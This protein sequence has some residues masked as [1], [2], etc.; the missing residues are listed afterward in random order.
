MAGESNEFLSK[1]GLQYFFGRLKTIFVQQESGKGL[2]T[3]DYTTAEKTKL[4]GIAAGA[5]ANVIETIK[6]NGA[7]QT[8]TSK[9]VDISVPTNLS[10]LANDGN[11]VTD[12]NYVHTDSNY[13]SAEKT[14][15]SGIA[16]GAQVNVIETVKVN[17]TAL[18]VTSKAVD[19]TVP[20]KTSDITNDSNYVAD[21]AY[22]HTE[23]NF[24]TTLKNKLDGIEEGAEANVAYTISMDNP[25][26]ANQTTTYKLLADGEAVSGSSNIIF[27]NTTGKNAPS[28]TIGM[29]QH[30]ISTAL[31]GK[32]DTLDAMTQSEA[33]TGTATTARSIT[34]AV[35]HQSIANAVGQITGISFEVV[36]TLPATGSAGVIYLVSNSG[37]GQNVY[38]EYI[39]VSNAFEKIG[40]TDVDL[41]NYWSMTNLTAITTAEIDTITA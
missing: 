5:Q 19:V 27:S 3:N 39:W 20:T 13:T 11:F 37:S 16:T 41:S 28:Y 26:G 33:D 15:L 10:D 30:A 8:V 6:V 21:S 31:D 14:K 24:T 22:V 4:S 9:A 2:S 17:G 18:A 12:A 36:Q 34:A 32:Q 7:A 35:L 40:T 29:T 25:T 38:D 1:T 23:N